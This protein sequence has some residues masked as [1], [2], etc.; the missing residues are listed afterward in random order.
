MRTKHVFPL[1]ICSVMLCLHLNAQKNQP[2][3]VTQ[4]FIPSGYMGDGGTMSTRFA[5]VARPDSLCI[6]VI[7]TPKK[8]GW[9]GVY[10]QFPAN[11]WCQK[12][13]LNLSV[14]SKLT[15]YVKGETGME[16]VKFKIGHDCGSDTYAQN[17]P[18]NQTL[19]TSWQKITLDLKGKD[20]SNITGAFA[21]IV[22][23]QANQGKTITFYLDDIQFE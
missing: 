1:L 12:D 21:W 14:C 6:R 11:N 20:L 10:W 19:T 18:L 8:D 2:V 9:G 5:D 23:S 3:I 15:F 17:P 16:N 7:Y 13:G 22:D 4:T